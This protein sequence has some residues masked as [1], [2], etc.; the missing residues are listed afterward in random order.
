MSFLRSV[1]RVWKAVW[2]AIDD[3]TL[4]EGGVVVPAALSRSGAVK[5]RVGFVMPP[6]KPNDPRP[7]IPFCLPAPNKL[8]SA[9]LDSR[10]PIAPGALN[11]V[12]R[13]LSSKTSHLTVA[14]DDA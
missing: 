14:F 10:N 4:G 6:P 1:C 13:D 2:A 9:A 8:V 12:K 11:A 3:I 7:N 5:S